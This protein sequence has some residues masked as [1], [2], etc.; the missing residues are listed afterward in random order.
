M[1]V[2]RKYTSRK[3]NLKQRVSFAHQ[4]SKIWLSV[5]RFTRKWHGEKT[6]LFLT[7]R[8]THENSQ[9]I[10]VKSLMEKNTLRKKSIILALYTPP[11]KHQ[12]I[13]QLWRV[14]WRKWHGEKPSFWGLSCTH[15]FSKNILSVGYQSGENNSTRVSR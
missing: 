12:K 7:N 5:G 8:P 1:E 14:S 10:S 13:L 15:E 6:H 3:W 4:N 11:T 2:H 9:N